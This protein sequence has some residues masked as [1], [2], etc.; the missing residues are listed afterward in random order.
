MCLWKDGRK[1]NWHKWSP[2]FPAMCEL[3]SEG[4]SGDRD[5]GPGTS[6]SPPGKPTFV[7]LPDSKVDVYLSHLRLS[8]H[9]T[10][11]S[12]FR[13]PRDSPCSSGVFKIG[14]ASFSSCSR[15]RHSLLAGSLR[16]RGLLGPPPPAGLTVQDV[17]A[18]RSPIL[19]SHMGTGST[20]R[21]GHVLS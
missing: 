15:S 6:F 11:K 4:P 5:S 16:S 10:T 18:G 2:I 1:L 7:H 19:L 12:L 13:I 14:C 9:H 8:I 17:P 21:P 20:E 3:V